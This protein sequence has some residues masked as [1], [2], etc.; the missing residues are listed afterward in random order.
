[1]N[2]AQR[3]DDQG[4]VKAACRLAGGHHVA[5]AIY[6]AVIALAVIG[7]WYADTT[8]GALETLLSLAATLT[9]FWIAHAYAHVAGQ[10]LAEGDAIGPH[11]RSAMR[12]DWPIVQ[13]GALPAIVLGLGALGWLPERPSMVVAMVAA[14]LLLAVFTAAMARAGG[15]SWGQSLGLALLLTALGGLVAVLEVLLG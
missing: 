8:S 6:G 4:I 2:D 9:V 7:A 15:R 10:G 11:V 3:R 1:M 14:A 12:G 13:S 5:S